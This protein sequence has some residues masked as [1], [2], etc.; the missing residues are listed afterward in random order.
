MNFMDQQ[1]QQ[2][3]QQQNDDDNN[4]NDGLIHLPLHNFEST[5]DTTNNYHHRHHHHH[6]HQRRRAHSSHHH[7]KLQEITG[8]ATQYVNVYIGTPAQKRTLAI[9]TGADFAAFPCQV[10]IYYIHPTQSLCVLHFCTS[11]SRW[12]IYIQR[13]YYLLNFVVYTHR[14]TICAFAIYD[15]VI[16]S[17]IH[18]YHPFNYYDI[19][20]YRMWTNHPL[21]LSILIEHLRHHPLR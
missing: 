4:N 14:F 15:S 8:I 3:Q 5:T 9:S 2:Q 10:N 12:W 17:M 19:G 11:S 1:Q 6:Y 18:Q 7:R 21:L 20:M 16:I 13:E